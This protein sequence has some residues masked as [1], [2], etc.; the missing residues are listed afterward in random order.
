MRCLT[1]NLSGDQIVATAA[2]GAI[3]ALCVTCYNLMRPY[4][5]TRIQVV[6]GLDSLHVDNDG[7]VLLLQGLQCLCLKCD[8]KIS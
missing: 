5:E 2:A 8:F 6:Q 4:I 7:A 1:D 3:G